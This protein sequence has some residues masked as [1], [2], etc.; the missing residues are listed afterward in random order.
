MTY[1]DA[2][3]EA[4]E[5]LAKMSKAPLIKKGRFSPFPGLQSYYDI[6]EI[7]LNLQTILD[8]LKQKDNDNV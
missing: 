7:M 5:L 4:I 8:N 1:K 2:L 6:D 3:E